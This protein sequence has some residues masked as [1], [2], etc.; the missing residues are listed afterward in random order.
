M[1]KRRKKTKIAPNTTV[2][3][4]VDEIMPSPENDQLYRPVD[5]NDPEVRALAKSIQTHGILEPLVVSK[6]RYIISGH[7]RY[8]A[9]RL[10]GLETVPCRLARIYR[11]DDIDAF[12]RRLR[13][14]NRQRNKSRDE[15]IREEAVSIDPDQAYARLRAARSE[16]RDMSRFSELAVVELGERHK[17]SMISFAKQEMLDAVLRIVEAQKK[18]WPLTVR[19]VHYGLLNDPPLRHNKKPGSR[20]QNN[21]ACYKDL[22]GLVARARLEGDVPWTAIT[23]ETRPVMVWESYANVQSYLTNRLPNMLSDYFRDLQHTQKN[24][25]EIVVEKMT[26][27]SI[28][29]PV[30]ADFVIPM[31]VGRGYGSLAPRYAMAQRFRK[32]GKPKLIVLMVTDFDPDGEGI[33][34]SFARSMRDDLGIRQLEAFKVALTHEQVVKF[35]LPPLFKAKKTSSRY[36]RFESRFGENVFEL[37][38]LQPAQLAEIVR[39][40]VM[41]VLDMD[42][43]RLEEEAERT[44]ATY[45][46]EIRERWIREL[47]RFRSSEP[48]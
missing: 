8:A 5:P 13:E 3:L 21:E 26:V 48:Q 20:Y 28:V 40:A 32:S 14:H 30:A 27:Q 18:F 42:A 47:Q 37:E 29:Q 7:R 11:T 6:D 19:Q 46:G 39:S 16:N 38:A 25:V 17:R 24:H 35:K 41:N 22:C 33:A 45:L 43:L 10:A 4:R 1:S 9:A 15:Q 2:Q 36:A 31:T 12:L 23:D 34:E 44:D